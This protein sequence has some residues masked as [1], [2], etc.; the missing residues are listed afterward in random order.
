MQSNAIGQS[1]A[2]RGFDGSHTSPQKPSRHD[3]TMTSAEARLHM[4]A[5]TK[6]T[7]GGNPHG[8]GVSS[9]APPGVS[10]AE[11]AMMSPEEKKQKIQEIA[12]AQQMKNC[13]QQMGGGDHKHAQQ[14]GA[15]QA[16]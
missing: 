15:L 9:S 1:G 12:M 10:E 16:A 13:C 11:W 3:K 8:G 2:L 6:Q 7:A 5:L 4:E 14:P